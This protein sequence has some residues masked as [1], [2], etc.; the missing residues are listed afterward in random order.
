MFQ[1]RPDASRKLEQPLNSAGHRP[2]AAD[3]R[4]KERPIRKPTTPAMIND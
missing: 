2:Q 4:L 3:P 1:F